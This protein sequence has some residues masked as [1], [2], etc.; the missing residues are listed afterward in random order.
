MATLNAK[1]TLTSSDSGADTLSL[2]VTDSLSV[3]GDVIRKRIA[4]PTGGSNG[5]SIIGTAYNK[6]Y[7]FVKNTDSSIVITLGP[8]NSS[9]ADWMEIGPGEFMFFNWDGTVELFANSDSGSPVL[10]LMIFEAT[11]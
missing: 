9:T 8:D 4:I 3:A 10:E 2:S 5:V 6:C 7:V 1:L 11:A